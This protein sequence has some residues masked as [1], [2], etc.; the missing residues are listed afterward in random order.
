MPAT[1]YPLHPVASPSDATSDLGRIL[2]AFATEISPLHRCIT[3]GGL[4]ETLNA[5][6]LHINLTIDEVPTGTNVLDWTIPKEWNIREAWIAKPDGTRVVDLKDSP[7]HVLQYSTPVHKWMTLQELRPHLHTLP[8]Q[9]SLI[10]Y[11]TSYYQEAWGFCLSQD[12]LDSLLEQGGENQDLEVCIDSELFDGS[13]SYGECVIPGSST[14][15]VLI[16]AHA[17][18]PALANDN[19]SALAVATMLAKELETR[20]NRYTYRF[21]FAPGTIGSIVWL[22]KNRQQLH[23]IKHGFVL[24]NMGDSG[25]FTYKMT[26]RGTLNEPLVVDRAVLLALKEKSVDVRSFEPSGYD[27]RQFASPGFDLPIGRLTRTPHGEYAEYHTSGDNMSLIRPDQLAGS[28]KALMDIIHVLEGN[29]TCLNMHP[30]GEPMLG[31]HDLYDR[32][33]GS[34]HA[35]DVHQALLWV[36]NLSDGE[37]CL[38]SIA[39]RSG[40]SFTTVRTAAD[41]L[42]DAG[43]IQTKQ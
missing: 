16:S 11:R 25:G 28:F 6:G 26:R 31:R 19:V 13:L 36:L 24:A 33:G 34:G 1:I 42:L 14:N 35:R 23:N 20:K 18:H 3:G 15:E 37:H 10:P 4:R 38:V 29:E 21:L 7:L 8:A 17:C 39:E 27:E 30:Y 9:P 43:L 12:T 41:K 2:Y 22:E 40:L 5:I 32:T